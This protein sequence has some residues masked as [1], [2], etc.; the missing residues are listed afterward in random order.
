MIKVGDLVIQKSY[1]RVLSVREDTDLVVIEGEGDDEMDIIS[2]RVYE[3]VKELKD[4]T[5]IW[6]K[7]N[8]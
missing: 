6:E 2:H 8:E 5:C 4:G 3:L 7:V 1:K